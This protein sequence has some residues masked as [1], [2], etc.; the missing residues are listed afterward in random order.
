MFL[1]F[2]LYVQ[3]IHCAIYIQYM[4]SIP[5]WKRQ[6]V[7]EMRDS[8]RREKKIFVSISIKKKERYIWFMFSSSFFSCLT[9]FFFLLS[10]L[11]LF[12]SYLWCN[13]LWGCSFS[14]LL[15]SFRFHWC[16]T[17]SHLYFRLLPFNERLPEVR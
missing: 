12:Y 11:L 7:S 4:C 8:T 9:Q 3:A 1:Y 13:A 10:F 16:L 2:Q 5:F 14:C 6:E 17:S 15:T